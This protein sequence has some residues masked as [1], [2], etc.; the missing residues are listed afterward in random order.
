MFL[1]CRPRDPAPVPLR[2]LEVS[3][4]GGHAIDHLAVRTDPIL[5]DRGAACRLEPLLDGRLHLHVHGRD[6]LVAAG[7]DGLARLGVI[8]AAQEPAELLPNLLDEMGCLAGRRRRRIQDQRLGF[9][10]RVLVRRVVRSG[11]DASGRHLVE[12][13]V[14]APDD[15]RRV[16]HDEDRLSVRAL[17]LVL[18]NGD[19]AFGDGV[20]DEVELGR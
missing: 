15:V 11:Q 6:D 4:H 13:L 7:V 9:G 3:E 5:R 20:P 14:P 1:P 16:G 10:G 17:L 2:D 8:L 12:D 19:L 18:R